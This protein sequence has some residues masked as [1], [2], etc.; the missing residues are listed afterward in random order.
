L[1]LNHINKSINV[2]LVIHL[3]RPF[4]HLQFLILATPIN[5]PITAP[6]QISSTRCSPLSLPEL[7]EH[8][9]RRT[10]RVSRWTL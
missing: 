3:T 9:Y 6:V 4:G 1:I 5:I 10:Y 2:L 8:S 7:H